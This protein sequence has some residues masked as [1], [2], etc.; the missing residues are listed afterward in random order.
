MSI[1]SATTERITT[2]PQRAQNV[3]ESKR[4]FS[5]VGNR[6][7]RQGPNVPYDQMAIKRLI[8][9]CKEQRWIHLAI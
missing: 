1:V 7:E 5:D 2:P 9:R 4:D 8:L 6:L 3:I